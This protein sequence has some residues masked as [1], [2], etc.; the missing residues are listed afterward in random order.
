MAYTVK[1][2][3]ELAGVSPRTLHFYEEIGLL[4]PA[5]RKNSYRYYEAKELF[6]L[7]KILLFRKLSLPLKQIR[8]I[9]QKNESFQLAALL[10]QKKTFLEEIKRLEGQV[11]NIDKTVHHF[12]GK[13][14][15]NEKELFQGFFAWAKDKKSPEHY[16]FGTLPS[17]SEEE[18]IVLE[19][20]KIQPAGQEGTFYE[21]VDREARAIY[22]KIKE[23]MEQGKDPD[24]K[25]VQR[26][27]KK[28]LIFTRKFHHVTKEVYE[29]LGSLYLNHLAFRG[30][31]DA[32]D[33]D[34]AP[35]LAKAMHIFS[36]EALS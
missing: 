22:L 1:E 9:L 19:S 33:R 3:S 35:F 28:H 31:L 18:R 34:L 12:R 30:Q 13:K 15:M 26:L 17:K 27:I 16:S 8:E 23:C 36:E 14:K 32:I 10:A 7:H 4:R 11:E 25:E 5:F 29:A 21:K 24:S 20:A 6:E 2:L